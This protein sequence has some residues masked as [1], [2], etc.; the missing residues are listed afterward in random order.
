[1]RKT[2]VLPLGWEDPLEKGTAAH[3]STLTWRIHGV[4]E[5][6]T[7]IPNWEMGLFSE[8]LFFL[9]N[10][11]GVRLRILKVKVITETWI[12][13]GTEESYPRLCRGANSVLTFIKR[14]RILLPLLSTDGE[15]LRPPLQPTLPSW[16]CHPHG[17]RSLAPVSRDAH[18]VSGRARHSSEDQPVLQGSGSIMPPRFILTPQ[19]PQPPTREHRSGALGPQSCS[20][21]DLV[22][23]WKMKMS[24][25]W[26]WE[27]QGHETRV[28]FSILDGS[29]KWK[30]NPHPS[31][32]LKKQPDKRTRSP[33]FVE[34]GG[35]CWLRE[36]EVAF[37]TRTR[38][39]WPSALSGETVTY[40]SS[41][42]SS[43][44]VNWPCLVRT[45]L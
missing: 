26:L 16:H 31:H 29:S 18:E 33:W 38:S 11:S 22:I 42:F 4:T 28:S 37:I 30:G 40:T 8:Y 10:S 5:S 21:Y 20:L 24:C 44:C 34:R 45:K 19:H 6:H 9:L 41:A 32:G 39:S 23:I 7:S 1:M 14:R 36:T 3:S 27:L 15:G 17:R 43:Q 25:T 13:V 12:L 2:W 35:F